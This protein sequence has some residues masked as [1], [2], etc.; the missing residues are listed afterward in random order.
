MTQPVNK[1]TVSLQNL[2]PFTLPL[3]LMAGLVWLACSPLFQ[4]QPEA[5]SLGITV[6]LIV[7]LPLSYLFL[8]R[9]RDIPNITAIPYVIIGVL[10][11]GWL[12]PPSHQF[13]LTQFKTW[14]LPLL[15]G[16]VLLVVVHKVRI[17]AK[18]YQ[19]Q[20]ETIPDV[21][22]ALKA[23]AQSVLPGKLGVLLATELGVIYYGFFCWKK[24]P[25]ERNEFS[26]HQKGGAVGC[27]PCIDVIGTDCKVSRTSV[28]TIRIMPGRSARCPG[29]PTTSVVAFSKSPNGRH[30]LLDAPFISN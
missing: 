7:I 14:G 2:L 4:H 19:E 5:L 8:I 10:L 12:I 6:D 23:A 9:N 18:H 27:N 30:Y 21:F 22:D 29:N 26:Y 1:A 11:A 3:L 15:E 28:T 24:K 16:V 13:Y 17:A 20:S 25:L